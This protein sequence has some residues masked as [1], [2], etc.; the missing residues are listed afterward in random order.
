V[1]LT[2]VTFLAGD[3]NENGVVD[4]AD[5]VLWRNSVGAT[6]VEFSGADGNGNGLIDQPDYDVWR[7]HFGTT[8]GSGAGALTAVA[9][10]EP[11][12]ALLLVIGALFLIKRR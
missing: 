7:S 8:L 5:Y 1:Q 4:S 2:A 11:T 9:I 10:P 3:Y 12:S 6:V